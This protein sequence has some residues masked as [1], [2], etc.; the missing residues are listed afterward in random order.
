V[1]VAWW[2]C[3]ASTIDGLTAGAT[4]TTGMVR[5]ARRVGRRG[6]RGIPWSTA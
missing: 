3:T 2:N 6:W 1:K 5:V 4:L